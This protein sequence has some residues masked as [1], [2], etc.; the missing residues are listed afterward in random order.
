MNDLLKKKKKR[1][2]R[3]EVLRSSLSILA[4]TE[5][6][7]NGSQ[8]AAF[9]T[10]WQSEGKS[11]GVPVRS[12]LI[13]EACSC[14]L[15]LLL[16]SCHSPSPLEGSALCNPMAV[17]PHRDCEVTLLGV[18]VPLHV[19]LLPDGCCLCLIL[20]TFVCYLGF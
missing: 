9:R 17:R 10:V 13:K 2:R 7:Q 11:S 16:H 18:H 14:L 19:P 6:K 8:L 15:L 1:K 3:Q 4:N 20:S 5:I 12:L